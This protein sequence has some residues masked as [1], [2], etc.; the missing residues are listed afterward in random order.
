MPGDSAECVCILVVNFAAER[1]STRRR[2]FSRCD[3]I[4][5]RICRAIKC[6]VHPERT[7]HAAREELVETLAG[8]FLD[9][10]A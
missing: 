10:H 6:V 1:I 9:D 5:K 3:S 2:Y 7:E 8:Y 4:T